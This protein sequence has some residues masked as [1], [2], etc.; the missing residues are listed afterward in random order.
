VIKD[1]QMEK[2]IK[3]LIDSFNEIVTRTEKIFHNATEEKI[4]RKPS[5]EIWSAAECVERLNQAERATNQL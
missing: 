2:T 4:N 5:P 1:Y 3:E